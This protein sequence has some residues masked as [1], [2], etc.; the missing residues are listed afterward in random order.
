MTDPALTATSFLEAPTAAQR[1]RELVLRHRRGDETAFEEFYAQYSGM[2]FNLTLRQCGQVETAQELT[3]EVFLRIFRSLGRF[4]G[5][6]SL[7]TWTY[8]VCLNHCR[9]KLGRKRLDTRSLTTEEGTVRDL[10]DPAPGPAEDLMA[11]DAAARVERAL[12]R[13]DDAY[14]EA[15]ILRDLEELS[16]KEIAEVLGIPIGT[17]R[18]RI[19]RGRLQLRGALEAEE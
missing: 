1:E 12:P 17:V 3:Q 4:R 15:V 14:R 11:V 9:S 6:S 5:R 13:L 2:V 19:A 18:S 7:K 8:R 10:P 16:Y